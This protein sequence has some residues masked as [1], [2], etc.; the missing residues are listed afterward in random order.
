MAI[1][2][3]DPVYVMRGD[4]GPVH[5]LMFRVSPYI[6]HLYAGAESGKVHIWDMRR[7]RELARLADFQEPCLSMHT[8]ADEHL[9][10]QRKGGSINFWQA[11]NSNWTLKE[12]VQTEYYGF[13]RCRQSVDH[14]IFIPLSNS[15]VGIFSLKT[16][17]TEL[18][19]DPSSIPNEK[20]LGE[21]MAIKPCMDEM[22][23]ILVTY[24][25]GSVYLWDVRS[26]K[27]LSTLESE[28]CPMCIDFHESLRLGIVGS[29]CDNLQVFS[30]SS[31]NELMEKTKLPLKN[32][33]TSAIAIRPD[34]KVFAA[35][36][37]DSRI[38]IISLKTLRP[39]A[40]LDQHKSTI[41]DIVYSTSKVEAYNSKCLMAAA[42]KDGNVSLWNLYN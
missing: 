21:V 25:G 19:L 8:V 29:P 9:I 1:L 3:P 34:M 6:E 22:K 20:S 28:Q 2:P 30:L 4:M 35:G 16:M 10:T 27:M 39:L 42:G 11:S 17:K 12:T 40:V 23:Y 38:R 13:C 37:W 24:D 26:K 18:E 15:R 7:N 33:G 31:N 41:H 32:P 5:S 14:A 36:G